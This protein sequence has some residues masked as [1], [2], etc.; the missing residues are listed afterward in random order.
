MRQKY[1]SNG[2]E[3]MAECAAAVW[4]LGN[5]F[6]MSV[7]V[8]KEVVV[9]EWFESWA[10][11]ADHID[12]EVQSLLLDKAETFDVV[13]HIPT[14]KRIADA[15]VFKAPV[16]RSSVEM[17]NIEQDNY[18]L[19]MKKI[20]YDINVYQTW[21]KKCANVHAA[22]E[23]AR[24]E[25]RLAHRDWLAD[26][27]DLFLHN[28][29][30]FMV[31]DIKQEAIISSIIAFRRD[32]IA[33]PMACSP[34]AVP[35]VVTV[36]WASPSLIPVGVQDKQAAVMT[37]ALHDNVD[38]VC[39]ILAPV[40]SY[41]K[42]KLH[43]QET[44]MMTH[45]THGGHNVDSHFSILFKDQ[46][47]SRDK[48]PLMYPGRIVFP[49]PLLDLSKSPWFNSSLRRLCRTPEISQMSASLMKEVEDL[50]AEALPPSTDKNYIHGAPKF[51]QLGSE[52]WNALMTG[53][54]DGA[55][56]KDI[57]AVIFLD[58]FVNVGE[59]LRAFCTQRPNYVT[60]TSM[61]WVGVCLSTKEIEW[62]QKEAKEFLIEPY[63]S[64]S[65][66]MPQGMRQAPAATADD[67][68][69][70]PTRPTMN[71]LVISADNRLQMPAAVVKE[72]QLKPKFGQQFG[73]WLDDFMTKYSV[74]DT[75]D[76]TI[77]KGDEPTEPANA[78]RKSS[79]KSGASPAKVPKLESLDKFIVDASD[80]KDALLTE[81]VLPGKLAV[82]FQIRAGHEVYV[83]NKST[84][85]WQSPSLCMCAGYGKGSFK[86]IKPDTPEENV[87]DCVEFKLESHNDIVI[88]NG[89]AVTVGQVV[90]EQHLKKPDAEV[91][92]HKMTF[93]EANPKE[94]VLKQT[95]KI[96]FAPAKDESDREAK[97][98]N[99]ACKEPIATFTAGPCLQVLWTV[100]WTA[101]GLMPVKP[102][103]YLKGS[104]ALPPG[105]A[106][107][108]TGTEGA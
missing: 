13:Q 105:K 86:L 107:H 62:I 65:L 43:L 48:R 23:H 37:W 3:N 24:R 104:I 63:E 26:C 49:G 31:W 95:H 18:T 15:H 102:A 72:W 53:M 83:L 10:A 40:W 92:Y 100:R 8:P 30:K 57:P 45:I 103:V 42:G 39:K 54:L 93:S 4:S 35:I 7:A 94:F 56:L 89:Q 77:V 9:N 96:M 22:H 12:L 78:K 75:D 32:H 38:S 47:D 28:C 2:L 82:S 16:S 68:F 91:C 19:L 59:S 1:T 41:S 108:C 11:G 52:A 74:S 20:E 99:I 64:G 58:L 51:A 97:N 60:T 87:S 36:N 90:S 81:A 85:L 80:I 44:Q 17:D 98:G 50:S 46:V 79:G 66:P 61:F 55:N 101:K 84:S 14:L 33:V 21:E 69:N 25:Q 34:D 27:A 73:A 71:V 70:I 76:K 106:C 5:E 29:T 88:F 6:I 67:S